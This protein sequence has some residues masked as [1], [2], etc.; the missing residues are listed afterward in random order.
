MSFKSITVLATA[1][2]G[3]F[4]GAAQANGM[5]N[6]GFETAGGATDP[7]ASWVKDQGGYTRSSDAHTGSFS[8]LLTG[9]PQAAPAAFF[10]NSVANGS[11]PDL[12]AGDTPTFSFWAK[13]A[14]LFT[15]NVKYK[16]EYLD[17]IGNILGGMNA[18]ADFKT[19]INDTTWTQI[20]I[21][22]T[23][24][25]G[26]TAAMVRFLSENGPVIPGFDGALT[27]T[28]VFIDDVN[29]AVAAPIPEPGTYAL[30]LAGLA[31]I[32]AVARRRRAAA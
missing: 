12:V 18:F 5:A 29:L 10:Q 6:G 28:T 24:P 31:G 4:A 25:V 2:L 7:A 26:A 11:M 8:A 30:M 15:G 20:S 9:L 3:L 13:G 32:G 19:S 23:V 17:G 22:T 14:V 27:Q 1:A 16:L 21:P